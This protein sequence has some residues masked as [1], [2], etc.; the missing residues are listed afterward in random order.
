M[1]HL[2]G[3]AG[4]IERN[5]VAV[6]FTR[7]E[8]ISRHNI[9]PLV[10]K[11]TTEMDVAPWGEDN[12][13]PQNIVNALAGAGVAQSLLKWKTSALYGGGLVY[14]HVIDIDKNGNEVFKCA[15]KG[16]YKEVDA[17]FKNNNI[18]R[19]FAEFGSDFYH[20]ANCWP[21]LIPNKKR[22][23][24]VGIVH[25]ESCDCRWKQ[26]NDKGEMDT[27]YISK[28]WGL[29]TE[30]FVKFDPEKKIREAYQDSSKL[31]KP[32]GKYIIERKAIDMY[33]PL[34]SLQKLMQDES[35]G[36]SFIL[37][38]TYP[39]P[40]KTY[41][42]LAPWDGV[43]V[44]G[45]I[46][47]AVK[48]PTMLKAFYENAFNIRYHIEI[49][50]N[51][52]VKTYGKDV[53]V[54]MDNEKKKKAKLD[55][56]KTIDDVLAGSDNQYKSLITLFDVDSTDH[57]ESGRIKITKLDSKNDMSSDLLTSG[58]ANHE[59]AAAMG[60][61]PN[62]LG[63][64]KPGGV[65][66]SNQGGSNIREGKL[67]HDAGLKL[68]RELALEPLTL[69]KNFNGWPDDLEFRFKDTVLLTLD[70]GKQTETTIN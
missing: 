10:K 35:S 33:F 9:A 62:I 21:E 58:T 26:M 56:L 67:E 3:N 12:R 13:F 14:G 53:W 4:Y 24:I 48:V 69:I 41:Y 15:K 66:S 19:Y 31:D 32:D 6:S 55:L 57:K 46:E 43:R 37:P 22:D 18:P 39:S 47:I 61:N 20:F 65:Y 54:A 7:N 42:Q 44:A 25:Q 68:D 23:K 16:E 45:W 36:N 28:L 17:F 2:E 8:P 29:L 34:E 63:I 27:V 5:S 11:L 64:G 70:K 50:E 59:I 51:Y 60:V 40:N 52:F 1:I 30:Q 38:V 49:P